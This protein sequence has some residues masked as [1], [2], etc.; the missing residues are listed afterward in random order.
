MTQQRTR[1]AGRKK[2]L[3]VIPSLPFGGAERVLSLLTREWETHHDVVVVVFDGSNAAYRCG[4]RIV[5]LRLPAPANRREALRV[6]VASVVHL[7]AVFRRERPDRII[8]FMEPANFPAAVAAAFAGQRRRLT[9]SVRID[10]SMLSRFRRILIPWL[11]RIAERVTAPSQGV[12]AHLI[13]MGLPATKVSAI[14]NPVVPSPAP[15]GRP[16]SP[17]GSPFVLGIGRL[18]PQKGF[19]RLLAAFSEIARPRLH[20]VIL[21]EGRQ[22]AHLLS[23][24]RSLGVARRL[25]LPGAVDD[26]SAW[27]QNAECFVLSSRHE[28]WPN[29]IM[30]AMSHGCPVVS[31]RCNY[32]PSEMID[33]YRNGI[34]VPQGHVPML[35]HAIEQVIDDRRLRRRFVAEGRRRAALFAVHRIADAWID[36]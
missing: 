17:L 13:R 14:P 25:H 6:A 36:G 20:L 24:S 34:L 26:V 31:F 27:Y 19:D 22:R 16:R 1:R 10:P 28:G 7:F 15:K 9:V 8:A 3:A 32:G 12:A 5:D 2:I 18:H 29:V 21:G 35:A 11:Y 4:G 33:H 30:E 23:L